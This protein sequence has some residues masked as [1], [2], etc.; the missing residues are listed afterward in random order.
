MI[1]HESYA[2]SL[3]T[4]IIVHDSLQAYEHWVF[5]LNKTL[6]IILWVIASTYKAML[7]FLCECCILLRIS[8]IVVHES[9]LWY[10][11]NCK[12]TLSFLQHSPIGNVKLFFSENIL[13]FECLSIRDKEFA[14]SKKKKLFLV[15]FWRVK[16]IA[17][18]LD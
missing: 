6:I 7:V 17:K 14:H 12:N 9:C 5:W 15:N 16:N 3:P 2:P 1:V 4:F 18:E 11:N 8:Q 10:L 13:R